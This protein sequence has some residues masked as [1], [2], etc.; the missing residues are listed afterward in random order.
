MKQYTNYKQTGIGWIGEIPERWELSK[1]KYLLASPVTDGPHS[2]PEFVDDGVPF[3]SV[4]GIQNGELSFNNKRFISRKDHNEFIKKANPKKGDILLGKAASVGKVALIKTDTE[5]SIWSPLALIKPDNKRINSKVLA[6]SLQ[7]QFL[8]DQIRNLSNSNTQLNLGMKDIPSL[9]VFLPPHNLQV[10]ISAY[11][12][13]KTSLIDQLISKN[14][15][16]IQLLEE[17]KQAIIN[18]AVTKGLDPNVKMK[19]SGIEWIGEIP[20]HWELKKM[21]HLFNYVKGKNAQQYTKE[22]I[23]QNKGIY[24]VYS[25]QTE[26][27]GVMGLVSN[28]DYDEQQALL[29]T[30]VGAKAMT[31]R[32]I[33]GKFS[34][35]QNCALITPKGDD[36]STNY[37][38]Y[39]LSQHFVY[40]KELLSQ[41][42]QPSLRFEDLDKYIILLPPKNEQKKIASYLSKITEKIDRFI[43]KQKQQNTLLQEYRQALISNAVTGKIDVR[44]EP[45][46]EEYIKDQIL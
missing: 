15:L 22:Y 36:T 44:D 27:E 34:L 35:S 41:I 7:T 23:D 45:I 4:D 46:P 39:N 28:F 32:S 42:M 1:L 26:N 3:I 40:E 38:L 8:Q 11:L 13:Y 25:G 31:V 10:K 30:T 5:F 33:N 17:K 37:Y 21:K 16:L 6:Y 9:I 29:V 24:P 19:D 18:Q 14:N 43:Q 2:T 12:D 20:E